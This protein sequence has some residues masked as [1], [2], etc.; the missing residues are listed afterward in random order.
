M[1]GLVAGS[2]ECTGVEISRSISVATSCCVNHAMRWIAR[3]F[4]EAVSVLDERAV[5]AQRDKNFADTPFGY[6]TG[7]SPK[8]ALSVSEHV[9]LVLVHL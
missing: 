5:A 6:E 3:D 4:V 9:N 1:S 2:A 7:A 8:V